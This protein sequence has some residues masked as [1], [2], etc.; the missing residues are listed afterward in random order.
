MRSLKTTG[1]TNSPTAARSGGDR[2]ARIEFRTNGLLLDTANIAL[3]LDQAD[4]PMIVQPTAHSDFSNA[5]S[6]SGRNCSTS[7]SHHHRIAKPVVPPY[8]SCHVP[9]PRAW[10]DEVLL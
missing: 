2:P 7:A 5:R 10:L 8:V 4:S 6:I 1:S 9:G 3:S